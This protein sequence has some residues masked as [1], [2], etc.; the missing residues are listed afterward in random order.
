MAA[1][2]PTWRRDAATPPCFNEAAAN[3]RGNPAVGQ[4]ARP[5]TAGFNEA[6]ANGRGNVRGSA[7]SVGPGELQ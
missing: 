7:C 1:E 5:V 3:G 2:I 4:G 6:A